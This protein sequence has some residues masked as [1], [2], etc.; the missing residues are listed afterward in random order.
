MLS[1][2]RDGD[3]LYATAIPLSGPAKTTDRGAQW[4]DD[5]MQNAVFCDWLP[6]CCK[7]LQEGDKAIY[8]VKYEQ[9]YTHGT[10][11]FYDYDEELI[12]TLVKKLHHSRGARQSRR[13][14]KKYY[15]PKLK[16]K[17]KHAT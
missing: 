8:Q 5:T 13:A 11:G 4:F 14:L 16:V 15:Q 1:V 6:D 7:K 3:S 2:E 10:F 12:F 9:S 17:L